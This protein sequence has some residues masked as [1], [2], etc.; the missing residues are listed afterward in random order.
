[1]KKLQIDT[2]GL[3][4]QPLKQS[5]SLSSHVSGQL[6]SMICNGKIPVDS[7]LPTETTLCEMFGVSRTVIR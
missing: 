3:E 2:T 1:M 7:K 6:E 4:I 5:G